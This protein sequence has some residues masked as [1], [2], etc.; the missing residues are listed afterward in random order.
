MRPSASTSTDVVFIPPEENPFM[1]RLLLALTLL[2]LTPS[3]GPAREPEADWPWWRGPNRDGIADPKQQPPQKWSASDNVVWKT[4]LPGRGHGSPIVV[5][6]QVFL[7]TADHA[8]ETQELLCFD[9]HNGKL[10]WQTTVHRGGFTKGGNGKSSHASST[11]ACDGERVFI[12][13]LHDGAIWTTALSREG[14][15]LWQTKVADYTLHQGFG[16]SPAVYKSLVIVTADNKGTGAIV[17]LDRATGKEV[18]RQARPKLPNYASPIILEAGGREQLLLTGCALVSGFEPLT[19]KKLW[20]IKG[21]TEECVTSTVTDGRLMF[22]SGGYPRNHVAAVHADGSGKVAWENNT[23]VYVPSMLV[24]DGHL[25][26]VTDAGIAM[27]WK[28]DSGKEVWKGRLGGTFSSSPVLVGDVC[29][30]TNEAGRTYLFKATPTAFEIVAEN[31]LDG[32]V[33]ATPTICGG[34]IFLR[35]AH[36]EKGQRQEVLYCFGKKE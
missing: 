9:R 8:R 18:W 22:T 20:E 15:Q 23:R 5:G 6:T 36:Q 4:P 32:E 27:C 33:F 2:G 17:A 30:A 21:S 19:G 24:K 3:F 28:C 12:N 14:K 10:L 13:F 16:S 31:A 26:A 25:Y 29:Y 7:A 11:P 34:R 35:V 1:P